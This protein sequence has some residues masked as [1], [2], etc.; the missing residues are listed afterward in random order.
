MNSRKSVVRNVPH[1]VEQESAAVAAD[2]RVVILKVGAAG[3]SVTLVG[4][5][6][7]GGQWQYARITKD[8]TEALLGESGDGVVRAPVVE[9]LE[10]VDGWDEALRL[11]DRYPWARLHPVAVHPEFVDRVRVAVEARL[12]AEP[13]HR[14]VERER[15]KWER[16]LKQAAFD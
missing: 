3:G 16:L 8:Q 4:R 14:S 7:A 5:I 13:P 6:G 11:M 15:W 2:G 9:S 1:E 12:T 10:W